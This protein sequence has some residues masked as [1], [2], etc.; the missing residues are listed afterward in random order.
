MR[1]DDNISPPPQRAAAAAAA[2]LWHRRAFV[3]ACVV[4]VALLLAGLTVTDPQHW[5]RW[6]PIAALLI[7]AL[8]A[9]FTATA[10][11]AWR[12]AT[13]AGRHACQRTSSVG[14]ASHDAYAPGDDHAFRF[15]RAARCHSVAW[16]TPGPIH[17]SFTWGRVIAE[18][19][20]PQSAVHGRDDCR[21]PLLCPCTFCSSNPRRVPA[22]L[23]KE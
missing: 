4:L 7:A 16:P 17:F 9:L 5:P 12:D 22:M 6:V 3:S 10:L 2:A 13:R 15:S 8:F 18:A 19:L 14:D 20:E 1:Q 11:A 23:Q 21:H